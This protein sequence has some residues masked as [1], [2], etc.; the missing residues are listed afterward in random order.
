M[1]ISDELR[2]LADEAGIY[3]NAR[4]KLLD[5]ADR[6][7]SELVELPKDADGV[8]INIGDTIYTEDGDAG[9][10]IGIYFIQ[11]KETVKENKENVVCT[12]SDGSNIVLAPHELSH[13]QPD[14]LERIADELEA[15]RGWRDQNGEHSCIV[16]SVS[17]K[18]L[19]E[20]AD[21]IRKLAKED[22]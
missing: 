16:S 21:R 22:E 14:S 17:T 6:I 3:S 5:L 9:D 10:V 11:H 12:L 7:D 19:Q 18:T 1:K 2:E 8:P 15:A 13:E 20:W 4:T